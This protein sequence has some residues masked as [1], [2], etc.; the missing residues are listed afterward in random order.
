LKKALRWEPKGSKVATAAPKTS[1]L[2]DRIERL[3]TFIRLRQ[4]I[5]PICLWYFNLD[6]EIRN[7]SNIG[8]KPLS[9]EIRKKGGIRSDKL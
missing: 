9:S 7:D 4:K 5:I 2:Q 3:G 1:S 6:Q 8:A